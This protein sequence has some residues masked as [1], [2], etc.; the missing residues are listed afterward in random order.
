MKARNTIVGTTELKKQTLAPFF[1]P[2]GILEC[3]TSVSDGV[4][5]KSI[6]LIC[7]AVLISSSARIFQFKLTSSVQRFF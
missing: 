6:V 2:T 1:N 4:M 7:T 3:L 5:V